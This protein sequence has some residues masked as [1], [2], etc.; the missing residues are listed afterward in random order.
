MPDER[1]HGLKQPK[2]NNAIWKFNEE[3]ELYAPETKKSCG[4]QFWPVE[5][6]IVVHVE[7]GQSGE[8]Y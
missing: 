7:C 6:A 4:L 8:Y 1:C 2:E 3:G 5:Q